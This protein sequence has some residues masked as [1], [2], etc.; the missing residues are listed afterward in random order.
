MERGF[1]DRKVLGGRACCISVLLGQIIP[2]LYLENDKI[3]SL[4]EESGREGV[5]ADLS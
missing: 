1:V 3:L 2:Y 5:V 4:I